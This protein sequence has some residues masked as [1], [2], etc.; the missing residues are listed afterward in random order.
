MRASYFCKKLSELGI[1]TVSGVPDS[2]LKNF[3]EY[4]DKSVLQ[5][6]ASS[7]PV[8]D[9]PHTHTHHGRSIQL[10]DFFTSP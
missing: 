4:L 6:V 9:I 7:F 5:Q 3:C 10:V 2:L 1:D 8:I